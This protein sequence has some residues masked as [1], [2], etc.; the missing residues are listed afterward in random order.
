MN[1]SYSSNIKK[2]D[3]PISIWARDLNRYFKQKIHIKKVLS[4]SI[5]LGNA[6]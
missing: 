2:A 4:V 3:N 5:H 1:N 6:N